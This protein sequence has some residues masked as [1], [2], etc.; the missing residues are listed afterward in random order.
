MVVLLFERSYYIRDKKV[1]PVVPCRLL[2]ESFFIIISRNYVVLRRWTEARLGARSDAWFIC[3]YN[4]I[5][6]WM[7]GFEP[8]K[9]I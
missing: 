2:F 6:T 1:L 8:G 9:L 3:T 4:N 7:N 5:I